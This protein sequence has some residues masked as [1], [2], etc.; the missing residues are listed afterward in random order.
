[1]TMTYLTR[2]HYQAQPSHLVYS[3]SWPLLISI[4][5]FCS[6]SFIINASSL[7]LSVAEHPLDSQEAT[8]TCDK[9]SKLISDFQSLHPSLKGNMVEQVSLDKKADSPDL[10]FAHKDYAS[11]VNYWL[12]PEGTATEIN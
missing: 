6:A 8:L 12:Y 10:Y 5:L 11:R 7:A 1:M 2:A 3:S 4:A 9:I